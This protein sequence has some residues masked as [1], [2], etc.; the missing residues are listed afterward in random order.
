MR[1]DAQ[2]LL[3]GIYIQNNKQP[4]SHLHNFTIWEA[5]P[6][7]SSLTC[8]FEGKG[9]V[10]T[11]ATLLLVVGA[12]RK[13]TAVFRWAWEPALSMSPLYLDQGSSRLG[14]GIQFHCRMWQMPLM[15]Q[16]QTCFRMCT[17]WS[18]WKSSCT[19]ESRQQSSGDTFSLLCG[20][21]APL[22]GL[23]FLFTQ[24]LRHANPN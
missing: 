5:K 2:V 3:I 24:R 13:G 23:C 19:G 22:A 1:L 11:E 14:S 16:W 20:R 9:I 18:L 15:P 7:V 6:W 21:N 8:L 12:V 4:N 10:Q 17:M